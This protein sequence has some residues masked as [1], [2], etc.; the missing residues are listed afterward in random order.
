MP[1]PARIY[2]APYAAPAIAHSSRRLAARAPL[3]AGGTCAPCS[4]PHGRFVAPP[5]AYCAIDGRVDQ[6]HDRL[7]AAVLVTVILTWLKRRLLFFPLGRAALA[8]STHVLPACSVVHFCARHYLQ[9]A[10]LLSLRVVRVACNCEEL[11]CG[12]W[13]RPRAGRSGS[14][15]GLSSRLARLRWCSCGPVRAQIAGKCPSPGWPAGPLA[16]WCPPL[17]GVRVVGPRG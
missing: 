17:V 2:I 9:L 13:R 3:L 4:R 16:S 7:N 5:L 6:S 14:L 11:R 10:A 8:S 15:A 12:M 1:M